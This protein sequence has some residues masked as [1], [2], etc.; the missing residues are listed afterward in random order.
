MAVG[1]STA[2]AN[3]IVDALSGTWL[4]LHTGDPGAAGTANQATE[5]TRKQL[6]LDT[7]ANGTADN[8]VLLEWTN[9]SGS[10]DATHFTLWS[11]SSGGTFKFSGTITADPYTAGD[12]FRLPVGN[13]TVTHTTRAA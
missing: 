3:A 10:Q 13:V 1:H 12:T 9:I 2:E 11:A 5:S 8:S 4:Q 6:T 7:A